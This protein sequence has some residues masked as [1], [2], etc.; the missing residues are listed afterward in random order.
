M[1]VATLQIPADSPDCVLILGARGRLGMALTLA[2]ARAGWRV[3][4]QA[5]PGKPAPE[6]LPTEV[7]WLALALTDRAALTAA[8]AGAQVVVNA[9]SPSN[10]TDKAWRREVPGFMEVA[11]ELSTAL[12]ATLMLPG[13]VYN[14]GS[15]LPPR[16]DE[17]T[18]FAAD[19]GKGRIRVALEE[20]M[21]GAAE[22]G[23]PRSIV[24]RAGDFFGSGTGSWLDL[25]M[26]TKLR[27]GEVS[28]PG[29]VDLP[30]AWAYLPDLA[31]TFV[32]VAER[33]LQLPA[34]ATLH[35]QGHTLS[36]RDWVSTLQ[37]TA[38]AMG[39]LASNQKLAVKQ[40]PWWLLRLLG[41]ASPM[42]A[43]VC[44]MRYLWSRPHALDNRRLQALIGEE[45]HTPTAQA[46]E[47]ALRELGWMA[48]ASGELRAAPAG[49]RGPLPRSPGAPLPGRR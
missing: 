37:S 6:N 35:F 19:T 1:T 34:F 31:Q 49:R 30:H 43:S 47:Q 45:P 2:F 26:A 17:H 28:L 9:L 42:V 20:R 18:P 4:A 29:P 48:S 5:R 38:R 13:N 8:A 21:R 39:W 32:R 46:V 16:L 7:R 22:T 3:L 12:K 14:Y 11:L 23:G 15:T 33:R 24:I 44:R 10:Y 41:L 40:V 27:R 36:G 25:V